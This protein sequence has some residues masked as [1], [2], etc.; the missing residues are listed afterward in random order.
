[1]FPLGKQHY[2]RVKYM[3]DEKNTSFGHELS[4]DVDF[5]AESKWRPR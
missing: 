1:M 5:M 4:D 3:V 2:N